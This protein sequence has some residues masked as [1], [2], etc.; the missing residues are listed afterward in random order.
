MTALLPTFRGR[1]MPCAIPLMCHLGEGHWLAG[2][3]DK[4]RQTLEEALKIT[5]RCG[6]RYYS[7]FAQR[8][9]GE[10]ALQTNLAQAVPHLEKSIAIC[11][12]IKAENELA[13]AFAGYGRFLKQQGQIARAREYLSKALEIF[14]RLGTLIEPDK[15]KENLEG[16]TEV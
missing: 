5:E 3:N 6:A 16:L 9:M 11:K 7:A 8:L 4:A 2:E 1:F 15:V 10:I 12:E 13:L 14:E